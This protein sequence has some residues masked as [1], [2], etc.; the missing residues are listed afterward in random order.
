MAE[1]NAYIASVLNNGGVFFYR[2]DEE[3][4][5]SFDVFRLAVHTA[6]NDNY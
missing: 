3:T 5:A 6:E 1:S 4:M 2:A